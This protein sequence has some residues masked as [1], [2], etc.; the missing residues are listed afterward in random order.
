MH[1]NEDESLKCHIGLPVIL[2]SQHHYERSSH[3]SSLDPCGLRE[4]VCVCMPRITNYCSMVS[5]DFKMVNWSE[6][7]TKQKDDNVAHSMRVTEEY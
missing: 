4:L 3:S 1:N 2:L 6:C 7:C 5:V